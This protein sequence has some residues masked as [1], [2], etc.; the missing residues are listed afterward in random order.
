MFC[1]LYKSLITK[2]LITK[3]CKEVKKIFNKI[4]YDLNKN[5]DLLN[6]SLPLY[7]TCQYSPNQWAEPK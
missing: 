6:I 2:T 5:E 3:Q 1:A 4:T 7:L